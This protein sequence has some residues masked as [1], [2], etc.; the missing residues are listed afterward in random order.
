MQIMKTGCWKPYHHNLK[1]VIKIFFTRESATFINLPC[2]ACRAA[3][4]GALNNA[5][6]FF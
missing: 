3:M 6:R 5:G 4:S 2:L 1:G